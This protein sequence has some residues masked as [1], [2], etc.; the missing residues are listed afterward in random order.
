MQQFFSR[1][2]WFALVTMAVL[3]SIG[4]VGY[5]TGTSLIFLGLIVA[6]GANLAYQK[7]D[8]ALA[9]VFIELFSNPHGALLL[10][11]V[12]GFPVSMRMALF[13]GV[14]LGW[15]IG[16]GT[17]KYQS[18]LKDGRAAIF[19][20]VMIAVVLGFTI[21]VLTRDPIAVFKDGNA[22]LYLLYLLPMLTVTWTHK[23]RHDLL[24]ILAAGAV[25]AA[26]VSL[27]ILYIFTHFWVALLAPVYEMLRDLRIAEVTDVGGGVY[28]VF[29]QSQMFTAIFGWFVLALSMTN[30]KKQWFIGLGAMSVAVVL[31]ALSR[32]FWVGLL[33]AFVFLL[34]MLARTRKP[35][36]SAIA[37][38][39]G[40]ST[41][42][43]ALGVALLLAVALF[44]IP[45]PSLAGDSLFASFKD[46]TTEIDDA[47]ISSR[48][49]LFTPM[50]STIV[51]SPL[52]GH[53]FGK[54]VTFESDDPRIRSISP[55]G[56]WSTTSMEWG[57]LELWI[58]MGVVGPLAFFY[59]AYELVRRLWSYQWTQQAWMGLALITGLVFIYSTHF[60]SPYLN[61]PI[62]L[63]YLLF[64]IPFLP[65]KKQAVSHS[66]VLI[67]ELMRSRQPTVAVTSKS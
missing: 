58:K 16:W 37:R 2:F 54:A 10:A 4:M 15:S 41:I 57:W 67:A 22:Y 3:Y 21:G 66:T 33:P 45:D 40:W 6:V 42:T 36:F 13:I 26:M 19:L 31:L 55:D 50:F 25:W 38:F 48:W 34:F 7:L 27:T 18:N 47:G 56:T 51:E 44:P 46:R 20:F 29:M 62:G 23:H 35:T 12:A 49:K 52:V 63:G 59:A 9:L 39:I 53:G 28:R 17:R 1:T 24:Q 64:L 32:S 14:M 65:D 61:H 60:F 11:D 8:L 30:Q 43:I 5:Y